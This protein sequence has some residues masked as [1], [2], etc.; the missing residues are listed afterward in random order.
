MIVLDA[1]VAAKWLLPE[2][3]SQAALELQDSQEELI[4]P[5]L[6]RMEVAA[7]ITR[8]VRAEKEKD[9]I[10]PEDAIE[11]CD[12]W[13]RLLEQPILSVIPEHEILDQA[14]KLSVEVKHALQDCLYLAVALRC[15]ATLIT[16]DPKFI[17]GFLR[18]FPR[19]LML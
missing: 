11:R 5:E 17:S 8:R 13:F 6:I 2:A 10:T 18:M 1:C 14:I 9:R 4:A 12:K 19:V 3:G 16:A 15:D 7:A